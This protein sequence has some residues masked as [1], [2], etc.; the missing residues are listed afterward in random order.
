MTVVHVAGREQ[1]SISPAYA[2]AV[3]AA[4][5]IPIPVPL[6]SEEEHLRACYERLDGLLL[7]GGGDVAPE[8]YGAQDTGL[9]ADIVPAR[10]A[11]ELTLARWALAEGL[12][13][14]GICRGIQVLNVAAGGG[15]IQ[16]IPTALPTALAHRTPP[17]MPRDH[18]AHTVRIAP[19]C[20]LGELGA[21]GGL[22]VNSTHH[23][24][25]AALGRGLRATAWAPDGI[26]EAVE[27][28]GAGRLLI[29]VQWHPEELV[30]ADDPLHRALFERLVQCAAGAREE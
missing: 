7:C 3:Q 10:D 30:H 2:R 6:L 15:L 8:A 24:A 9:C 21:P 1:W 13:L 17:T 23:Q 25:V 28:D 12:P 11:L 20:L 5:G 4:G 16:D 22:P 26:I 18:P 29:G 19:D 27:G 14:L